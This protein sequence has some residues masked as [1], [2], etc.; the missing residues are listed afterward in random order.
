MRKKRVLLFSD[1]CLLGESVEQTL[2]HIEGRKL[3]GHWRVDG[4]VMSRLHKASPDLVILAD[5]GRMSEALLRLT[6]QI[7]DEQPALPI[8]RVTLESNQVQIYSSHLVPAS[9]HGLIDLIKN[10]P[11][12]Q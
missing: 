6:A 9:S 7:L 10:L 11:L 4:L 1:Q 12:N 2:H 5:D 3:V 8:L